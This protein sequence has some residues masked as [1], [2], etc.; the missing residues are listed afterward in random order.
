MKMA[1]GGFRPAY[2]VL[3]PMLDDIERRTGALP[4]TLLADAN[5]TGLEGIRDAAR[6]GVVLLVPVPERSA[7]A[8]G[9][10]ATDDAIDHFLVRGLKRVTAVALLGAIA[11]NI[12]RHA[13]TLL[14]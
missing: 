6:R 12:L 2:N 5:H 10:G 7:N 9:R 14:A 1:D 8:G 13:A 4:G 11:A 3:A